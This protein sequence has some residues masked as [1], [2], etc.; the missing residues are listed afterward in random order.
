MPLA[1]VIKVINC[2]C[3]SVGKSGYSDVWTFTGFN[4]PS[5]VIL[6]ISL[7]LSQFT[8]ALI[9]FLDKLLR[10]FGSQLHNSNELFVIAA[11]IAKLPA[12]ILSGITL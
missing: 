5:E 3:K 9:S 8:P 1:T 2:A 11:A 4:I 7:S 6:I 10:C 12:S